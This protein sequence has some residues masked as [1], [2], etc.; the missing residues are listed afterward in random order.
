[1]FICFLTLNVKRSLVTSG[2]SDMSRRVERTNYIGDITRWCKDM[3]FAFV[4][5]N[6]ILRTRAVSE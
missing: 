3:N 6:N 4:C 2:L 5:Q 1:M